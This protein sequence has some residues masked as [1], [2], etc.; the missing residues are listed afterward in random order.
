MHRPAAA[1]EFR[2]DCSAATNLP[3]ARVALYRE[4][5][6]DIGLYENRVYDGIGES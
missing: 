6:S 2:D 4:R 1:R 5:F 3:T